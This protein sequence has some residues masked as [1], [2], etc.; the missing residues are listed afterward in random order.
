[1]TAKANSKFLG[2]KKQ[3]IPTAKAESD[4]NLRDGFKGFSSLS[5]INNPIESRSNAAAGVSYPTTFDPKERVGLKLIA[6]EAA[7][8]NDAILVFEIC[9]VKK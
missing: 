6:I 9:F 7:T 1:M 8:A 3:D 4:V 2:W 5:L